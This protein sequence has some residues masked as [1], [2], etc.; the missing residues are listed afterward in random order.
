MRDEV[1]TKNYNKFDISAS[2][3]K[4]SVCL[5]D[6]YCTYDFEFLNI[7]APSNITVTNIQDY[8]VDGLLGLGRS[9]PFKTGQLKD[10]NF[11]RGNSLVEKMVDDN[12]I[13]ESIF[14]IALEQGENN[15]GKVVF[16]L[17]P[18]QEMKDPES[19]IYISLVDDLFWGTYTT[20]FA[21]GFINNDFRVPSDANIPAHD[22]QVYT[23]F[24]SDSETIR[25]PKHI[26]ST[27]MDA[28]YAEGSIGDARDVKPAGVTVKC[29]SE[30]PQLH[31]LLDRTWL[32]VQ[33]EDYVTVL[34][35][36]NC[37]IKIAE[38]DAPFMVL[39]TPLY[40]GYMAIHD[41]KNGRLGFAP[42]K[43]SKKTGPYWGS[44][45]GNDFADYV[46]PA[47]V[48]KQEQ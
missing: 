45:P 9:E 6:D 13:P 42:S 34:G 40:K 39:G 20:G 10:S 27:Y 18:Q 15:K 46:A 12:L 43:A 35:N 19:L 41:D 29:V 26:F 32:T 31:F 3:G 16:G 24:D 47:P 2:V 23:I 8:G 37:L 14:S 38:G 25:M 30:Y 11:P 36:G 22:G 44:T 33:A 5:F 21:F 48:E 28:L 4:D 17:P 1:V 7:L